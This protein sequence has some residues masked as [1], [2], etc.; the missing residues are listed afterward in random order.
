MDL[1]TANLLYQNLQPYT[2]KSLITSTK[3]QVIIQ[4]GYDSNY[5]VI[6]KG[7]IKQIIL[8]R[9]S[10]TDTFVDFN[11]GDGA[12]A[13]NYAIV[14]T[15]MAGGSSQ[16]TQLQQIAAPM[17]NMGT[18]LNPTM[19]AFQPKIL[20]RGKTI[21][22]TSKDY[23]RNI[24]SQNG[25]I[26]SI[27]NGQIQFVPQNGYS[28][29][30]SVVLTSKTGMIGTPQQT[31]IGVNVVC[32][33]NPL[34]NPGQTIQINEK[35]IAKLKLDLG[36]PND[37]ANT[38]PPLNADGVYYA[39]IIDQIGDNRGVDWYSK[40]TCLTVKPSGNPYNSVAG[41]YGVS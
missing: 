40:L 15:T 38:A 29:G 18:S 16:A 31:N 24:A 12:F 27:Q 4:G 36:N 33:M 35:S 19:P 26:W 25:L 30:V 22:G 21:W 41:S 5:G 34:I 6:F 37:P 9:E 8:G 1:T 13:Y 2:N 7:N 14:N 28:P 17:K 20:P 11:C 23:L 3:G 39:L 32:L 10:A